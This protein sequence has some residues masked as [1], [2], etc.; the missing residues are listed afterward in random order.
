[1]F[2][3][4][5]AN[6]AENRSLGTG[7]AV[8]VTYVTKIDLPADVF[9]DGSNGHRQNV[10][11]LR[12]GNVDPSGGKIE[13]IEKGTNVRISRVMVEKSADLRTI[14]RVFA[15]VVSGPHRGAQANLY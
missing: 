12:N 11:F 4:C 3:S 9:G 2:A 14:T 13:L 5:L 15:T 6:V 1:L 10:Q 7:Y 8:G